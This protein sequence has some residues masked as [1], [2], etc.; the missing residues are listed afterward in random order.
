MA[1]Q[2]EEFRFGRMRG[3]GASYYDQFVQLEKG[4]TEG[5]I[6]RLTEE[7]S[8]NGTVA[9]ES[10]RSSINRVANLNDLKIRSNII[11]E[12]GTTYLIVQA[13]VPEEGD[14]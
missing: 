7:D 8:P 13:Y 6:W 3:T 12:D 2:L 5:P 1:E 10:I 4:E 9:L 14:E 11:N